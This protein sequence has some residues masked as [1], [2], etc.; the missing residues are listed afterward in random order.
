MPEA[1]R[2]PARIALAAVVLAICALAGWQAASP[3]AVPSAAV[4]PS[5]AAAPSAAVASSCGSLPAVGGPDLRSAVVGTWRER[6]GSGVVL[7][8]AADGV[9][10]LDMT[11]DGA[12][13]WAE[14]GTFRVDRDDVTLTCLFF[15]QTPGGYDGCSSREAC[16][17]TG[18]VLVW[19]ADGDVFTRQL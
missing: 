7:H 9:A 4:A 18:G 3:A 10:T 12:L 13:V 15:G 11:V 1:L 8:L 6:G 14:T 5:A 16:V 17:Y 19:P 2:W